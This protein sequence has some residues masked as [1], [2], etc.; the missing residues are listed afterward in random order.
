MAE[1]I[2]I[3]ETPRDAMQ[4]IDK[5]IPTTQKVRLINALLKVGFD[6]VDVGSF[7]SERAIPQLVDMEEVL[8]QIDDPVSPTK[9]LVLVANEKGAKN[10]ISF[11]KVD[12]LGFPFSTSKTFL[13]KN[14]NASFD[15]G[16]NLIESIMELAEPQNKIL[17][18]YL[19][20]AFGNPYGDPVNVE[21]IHE[22]TDKLN[23]MGIRNISLSD[24]IGNANPEFIAKTYR[25]LTSHYPKIEFGIHL[26]IKHDEWED[27]VEAA[28]Q[29]GCE[30][31]EGVINGLGG[32][33]MTGYE[34]FGNLPTTHII[35]FA[36]A[37]GLELSIQN[38]KFE[39]AYQIANRIFSSH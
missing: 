26:H 31:F 30:L 4:G 24:I 32:C 2:K 17:L 19:S 7:V 16:W 28:Y 33:P 27:K 22:F 18:V 5:F 37:R 8:Q 12:I 15:K 23:R 3:L 35:N 6:I 11:D 21:I 9:I 13:R 10:A 14:I 34:M 29:N 39:Y 38:E 20:M 36:S 1:K 25:L